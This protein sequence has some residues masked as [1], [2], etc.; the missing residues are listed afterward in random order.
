MTGLNTIAALMAPTAKPAINPSTNT[1][2]GTPRTRERLSS[3]TPRMISG[4]S[5]RYPAS[6]SEGTGGEASDHRTAVK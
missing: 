1:I 2:A 6:A 5:D 3:S 4:G